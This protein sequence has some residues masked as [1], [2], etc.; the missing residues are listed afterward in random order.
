MLLGARGGHRL[1]PVGDDV[2]GSTRCTQSSGRSVSRWA[3]A[4]TATAF[5]SSGVTLRPSSTALQ[6]ASFITASDPR[7]LA[8]TWTDGLV[9]VAATTSTT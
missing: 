7:G 9:R 4:G 1:E 6:R 5:T 2:L 8:P 3:R